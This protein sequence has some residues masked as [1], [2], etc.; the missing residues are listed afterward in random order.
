MEMLKKM[1]KR[2]IDWMLCE[3]SKKSLS[4][5]DYYKMLDDRDRKYK[6]WC[7]QQLKLRYYS[8]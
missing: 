5:D 1:L 6:D 3:N 8:K 2:M 4:L 7:Y